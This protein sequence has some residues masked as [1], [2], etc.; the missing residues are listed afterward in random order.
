M[1]PPPP[2][3]CT[4]KAPPGAG[5]RAGVTLDEEVAFAGRVAR[6]P[7]DQPNAR[8]NAAPQAHNAVAVPLRP[9]RMATT[10]VSRRPTRRTRAGFK[11]H[12][13]KA[14]RILQGRPPTVKSPGVLWDR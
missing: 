3:G 5:G 11:E 14:A 7:S 9:C 12:S 2:A 13:K 8:T 4:G 1:Q 10:V 6:S